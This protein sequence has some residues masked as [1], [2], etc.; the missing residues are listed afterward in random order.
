MAGPATTPLRSFSPPP[1]QP[2]LT[3]RLTLPV[4]RPVEPSPFSLPPLPPPTLAAEATGV[5]TPPVLGRP[6][7]FEPDRLVRETVTAIGA[8]ETGDSWGLRRLRATAIAFTVAV[9]VAPP[10]IPPLP[11]AR[12][13]PWFPPFLGDG[14][15]A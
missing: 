13:L 14:V 15:V 11:P 10:A 5:A 4:D 7:A 9:A 2:A 6:A 12:P 3:A 1:D 8:M